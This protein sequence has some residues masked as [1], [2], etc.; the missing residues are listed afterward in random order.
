MGVFPGWVSVMCVPSAQRP[1][2]GIRSCETGVTNDCEPPCGH[3][4]VNRDLLE[5][6]PVPLTTAPS[7]QPQFKVLR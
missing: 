7:H 1:K 2:E 3:G 6:Q 4:E 5:E